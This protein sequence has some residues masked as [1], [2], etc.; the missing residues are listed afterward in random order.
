MVVVCVTVCVC[1]ALLFCFAL[2]CFVLNLTS[3]CFYIMVSGS[4]CVCQY[5]CPHIYVSFSLPLCFSA[6][7][8]VLFCLGLFVF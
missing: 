7:L 3:L 4:L 6:H 5:V 8:F 2:F 1:Y